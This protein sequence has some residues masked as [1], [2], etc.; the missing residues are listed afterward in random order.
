[1]NL[2]QYQCISFLTFLVVKIFHQRFESFPFICMTP[3]L[4][5]TPFPAFEGMAVLKQ[6]LAKTPVTI[7]AKERMEHANGTRKWSNIV[8]WNIVE[9][10]FGTVNISDRGRVVSDFPRSTLMTFSVV[11]RPK[12]SILYS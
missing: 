11:N 9:S 4:L 6:R 5:T 3:G 1:M 8:V 12:V 2:A 10:G 7:Q